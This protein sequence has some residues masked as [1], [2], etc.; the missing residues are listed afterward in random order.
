MN[1]KEVFALRCISSSSKT[2]EGLKEAR[3]EDA[4]YLTFVQLR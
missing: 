4:N 1:E 3:R 2:T